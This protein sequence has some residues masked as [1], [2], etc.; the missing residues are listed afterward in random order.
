[1]AFLEAAVQC[2]TKVQSHAKNFGAYRE[3]C[4]SGLGCTFE[5][6]EKIVRNLYNYFVQMNMSLFLSVANTVNKLRPYCCRTVSSFKCV[7]DAGI[8]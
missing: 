6:R 1:M 7:T 2:A 4:N 5:V 8:C 3:I